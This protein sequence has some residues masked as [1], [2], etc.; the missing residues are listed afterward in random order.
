[1]WR[2]MQKCEIKSGDERKKDERRSE[3]MQLVD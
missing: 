1:M 3:S 2:R